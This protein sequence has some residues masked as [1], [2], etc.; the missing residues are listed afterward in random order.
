MKA[1]VLSAPNQIAC[2]TV[3]EPALNKGD[4]LVKVRAATLCGTDLRIYRGKKTAGIRYP[5]IPGHEFAGEVLESGGND[6]FHTGQ[7]V[8]VCPAYP[9]GTCPAC[10]SDAEN[11]CSNLQAM[12]YQLEGAF[13]DYV[14]VPA[15]GVRS[16]HVL[17]L[18]DHLSYEDAAMAEPLACVINGQQQVNIQKGDTVVVLG[19][20][21]IGLL[22]VKL[23]RH[24]GAGKIIVSQRSAFRRDAAMLAGADV[25]IDPGQED[26]TARVRQ[27]TAGRGADVVI[28]AIGVAALANDALH[29][30]RPRGR[31]NLFAG[32]SKGEMAALDVNA[33]H[34]NEVFVSG[35]FGLTRKQ[36]AQALHL[37]SEGHVD[38]KPL[39]SHR[40]ALEQ[41]GEAFEVAEQGHAIK[42]A[43]TPHQV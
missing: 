33:L 18:P 30:V 16:G 22:H 6:Q 25:A 8:T 13:A 7:R 27:E 4:M 3:A 23:A 28:C 41:I 32:F 29:M 1:A 2:A 19:A 40:F 15:R 5:S 9:C 34:Y 42:V 37:I 24:A 38:V 21:P 11:L 43:I 26:V 10:L 35:A 36:F 20:G 31:V 39:I 17:S 14:V 12:G